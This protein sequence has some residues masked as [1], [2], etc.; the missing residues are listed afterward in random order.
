[1]VF[2]EYLPNAVVVMLDV[3]AGKKIRQPI[4]VAKEQ[5]MDL[6]YNYRSGKRDYGKVLNTCDGGPKV[7]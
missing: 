3:N 1:M 2:G 5:R 4:Y 6:G 7:I